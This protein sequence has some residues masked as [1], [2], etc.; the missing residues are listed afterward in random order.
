MF[1]SQAYSFRFITLEK[2][3]SD[4]N[5]LSKFLVLVIVAVTRKRKKKHVSKEGK[6]SCVNFRDYVK[7]SAMNRF[8]A[9]HKYS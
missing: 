5:Y 1:D 4:S 7:K 8:F 3:T 6:T 2:H 9:T